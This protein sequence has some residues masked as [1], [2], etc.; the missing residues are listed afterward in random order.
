MEARVGRT[1]GD[2]GMDPADVAAVQ[3]A[4]RLAMETRTAQLFPHH[5][6]FLHP[7]RTVLILALDCGFLDPV[8]LAAAALLESERVELRTAITPIRQAIG[9]DVAGWVLSVPL[10]GPELIEALLGAPPEVQRVALA[11]R[12]D[13]CRHAKFW[14]DVGA[15][16]RILEEVEAIY[17][18]VAQ[19]TEPALGRRFAHWAWAFGRSLNAS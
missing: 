18:P 11:E 17:G 16:R 7:G 15:K 10:P 5:P 2:A 1:L 9:D 19:R 3:A 13:H 6:D 4:H 14:T 8:G 12:L